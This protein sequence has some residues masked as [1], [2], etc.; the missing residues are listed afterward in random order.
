MGAGRGSVGASE[1]STCAERAGIESFA[2]RP[3][4]RPRPSP[5][6]QW[7]GSRASRSANETRKPVINVL[8]KNWQDLIKP[9]T[10]DIMPGRDRNKIATVVAD[11]LERG[12]GMTLGNALRRGGPF[13]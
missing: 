4:S 6:V 1:A 9:S 5:L 2:R 3:A 7:S 13:A 11:P 12:F 10:L 8:Q